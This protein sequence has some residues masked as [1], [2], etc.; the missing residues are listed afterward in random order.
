MQEGAAADVVK[1]R[2]TANLDVDGPAAAAL[3]TVRAG[4][5]PARWRA[6]DILEGKA[7]DIQKYPVWSLL[8]C[9]CCELCRCWSRGTRSRNLGGQAKHPKLVAK[10][11]HG[12]L[13]QPNRSSLRGGPSGEVGNSSMRYDAMRGKRCVKLCNA[14]RVISVVTALPP[15]A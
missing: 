1:E 15:P 2:A 14:V 6:R 12:V 10:K 3:K 4:R 11:R 5:A 8:L 7:G 9:C 13:H